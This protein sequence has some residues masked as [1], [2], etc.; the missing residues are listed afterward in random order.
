DELR[1]C[2]LAEFGREVDLG[3]KYRIWA[4]EETGMILTDIVGP[5]HCNW[6][7]ASLLHLENPDGTF[8]KQYVRDPEGVL[9]V[10]SLIETYAEGV[11][12]PDDATFSGYATDD[13][14]ELWFTPDDE[15]AY[16][17]TQNGVERWPRAEEPILCM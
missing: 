2:A 7:S 1:T 13:G 9:P 6:Q 12:M 3:P 11:A 10:A 8:A 4:H 15:A 17:V 5:A 16:V 14:L